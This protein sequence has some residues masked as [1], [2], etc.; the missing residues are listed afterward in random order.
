MIEDVDQ[1]AYFAPRDVQPNWLNEPGLDG[2]RWVGPLVADLPAEPIY[3]RKENA[4]TGKQLEEAMDAM[5][6]RATGPCWDGEILTGSYLF[7]HLEAMG[8]L[9]VLVFPIDAQGFISMKVG[10]WIKNGETAYE[11]IPDSTPADLRQ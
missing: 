11:R 6:W 4:M 10:E 7:A 9:E 8:F 1:I 5:R 2:A 3:R